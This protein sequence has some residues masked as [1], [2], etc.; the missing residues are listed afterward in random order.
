[1]FQAKLMMVELIVDIYEYCA[2]IPFSSDKHI[3]L[4]KSSDKQISI[5]AQVD[6]CAGQG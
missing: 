4:K 6:R 5:L 2:L 1:M 3:T